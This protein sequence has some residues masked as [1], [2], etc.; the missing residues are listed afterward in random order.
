MSLIENNLVKNSKKSLDILTKEFQSNVTT[1]IQF[2][3]YSTVKVMEK[4]K[5]WNDIAIKLLNRVEDEECKDDLA[6]QFAVFM[7]N[8]MEELSGEQPILQPQIEERF[9]RKLTR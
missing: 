9:M 8:K 6:Y 1:T 4:S 7:I 5:Q 3:K 2:R